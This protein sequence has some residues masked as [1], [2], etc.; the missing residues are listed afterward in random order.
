MKS[1]Q[2]SG[3]SQNK[4]H[5]QPIPCPI[6]NN[7]QSSVIHTSTNH[8]QTPQTHPS[9]TIH[10]GEGPSFKPPLSPA[11][12]SPKF[13]TWRVASQEVER[14]GDLLSVQQVPVSQDWQ[15][16]IGLYKEWFGTNTF[17]LWDNPLQ[18]SQNACSMHNAKQK[19]TVNC[20]HA[21]LQIKCLDPSRNFSG[22]KCFR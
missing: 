14:L 16:P 10:P 15:L 20:P 4:V 5:L 3:T 8:L 9:P 11:R 6:H 12:R 22:C 17:R 19:E 1:I 7:R 21:T 13:D 18:P 2:A